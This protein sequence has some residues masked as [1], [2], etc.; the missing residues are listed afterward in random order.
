M[1]IDGRGSTRL[2]HARFRTGAMALAL[3]TSAALIAASAASAA[4]PPNT[5]WRFAYKKNAGSL[6]SIV[7]TGARHAWAVGQGAATG[8]DTSASIVLQWNGRS[9]RAMRSFPHGYLP[10]SVAATGPGNVWVFAE[11][12]HA[13]P[14]QYDALRWNGHGWRAITMPSTAAGTG[15]AAVASATD[16]WYSN[17]LYLAHWDGTSWAA[18]RTAVPV[19]LA[20]TPGG[21]IWRVQSGRVGGL[22]SR[23]IAQ[24]WDGRDWRWVSLPHPAV[25]DNPGLRISIE[26]G[27]N[28]VIETRTPVYPRRGGPAVPGKVLQWNGHRWKTITVPAWALWRD[29]LAATGADWLWAGPN[30]L[31]DGRAWVQGSQVSGGLGMAGIPGTGATWYLSGSIML[32]GRI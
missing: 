24:R 15:T 13:S 5:A 3:G 26:S 32:N 23:L 1:N 30:A 7:A 2:A 20:A 22:A 11:A 17:G 21:S 9:W 27:S 12:L 10:T 28:I 29:C 4:T 14:G 25:I 16:V 8:P 18:S 31:W 19:S 6:S